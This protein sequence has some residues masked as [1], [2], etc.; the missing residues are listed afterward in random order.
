MP[1]S[2][3]A[4]TAATETRVQGSPAEA[5]PVELGAVFA[6]SYDLVRFSVKG[7]VIVIAGVVGYDRWNTCCSAAEHMCRAYDC[8]VRCACA[9][10][11]DIAACIS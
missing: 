6:R 4:V 10:G 5:P 7:P 1:A 3:G 8:S 2:S 11:S 9:P